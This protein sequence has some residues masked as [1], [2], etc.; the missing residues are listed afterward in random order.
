[1]TETGTTD[2]TILLP[3]ITTPTALVD[4]TKIYAKSTNELYFQDGAGAEHNLINTTR[5]SL[6]FSTEGPTDNIDVTDVGVVFVNTSGNN[7][8]IGGFVGGV[9]AQVLHI[10]VV[11]A[12]S[13]TILEHNE[14]TGNQ[15]VFL[16]SGGDETLTASY[17][18]W[19]L[20]CNGTHWY[21]SG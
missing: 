17:G 1:M 11:D 12:T 2:G 8:T 13:N 6:A 5:V 19:T 3:E 21:E 20:I 18:G 4:H 14:G 9:S 16:A 7:V 10:V 15:D